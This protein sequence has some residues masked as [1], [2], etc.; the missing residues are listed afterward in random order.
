MNL[1]SPF[2]VL[3]DALL[4]RIQD[5]G[6]ALLRELGELRAIRPELFTR[7]GLKLL[8]STGDGSAHQFLKG[9]L[10]L[11]GT[12]LTLN[13]LLLAQRTF[14]LQLFLRLHQISPKRLH[15]T[16]HFPPYEDK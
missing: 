4:Q 9:R 7:S 3:P 13:K 15:V 5:I 12:L 2:V 8:N 16:R 6:K 10:A 14:D 1:V 11:S